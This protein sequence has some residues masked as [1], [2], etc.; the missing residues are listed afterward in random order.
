VLVKLESI[1]LV[2][3]SLLFCVSCPEPVAA[4]NT[5]AHGRSASPR[6]A[7]QNCLPSDL[8]TFFNFSN[9]TD[10]QQVTIT[11]HNIS[12]D[13]CVLQ[14]GEGA[15]FG[16]QGHG[17]WTEECRNCERD[18]TTKTV[19]SLEI[20]SGESGKMIIR[21]NTQA[22][23]P[24]TC[25]PVGNMNG[26]G[27]SIWATGL[28][29]D[30][31][32]VVYEDSYL[33]V[34]NNVEA[35]G[36]G[37][38][39]GA[40]SPRVNVTLSASDE[41]FYSN[42]SLALHVEIEDHDGTL[43]LNKDFCPLILMRMRG[44]GGVT[45]L[46]EAFGLC[47]VTPLVN[48]VGRRLSIDMQAQGWGALMDPSEHTVQAFAVLGSPHAA[49]VEMATSNIL[50]LKTLDP[51]SIPRPWGS[52]SQGVAMSL[53]FDKAAYAIGHDIP[54]RLE[55]PC[56]AG[57]NFELRN[58]AGQVITPIWGDSISICTGHGAYSLYP[59]GVV[60][61][62]AGF[63]LRGLGLLPSEPGK[64]SLVVTWAA[65]V[66]DPDHPLNTYYAAVGQPPFKPYAM[67]RSEPANFIVEAPPK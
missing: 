60:V 9:Q 40:S 52:Q 38:L 46:Q 53:S 21:W 58:S 59:K 47:R 8:D 39:T 37:T 31:C 2:L 48:E 55:L 66:A 3:A 7:V 49:D 23:A 33:R 62:V 44:T 67:V 4:Q 18:G 30:L 19:A 12:S 51:K 41:T 26:T 27:W 5:F 15:S 1:A 43:Q 65:Q 28:M 10:S 25:L 34:E 11:F 45:S 22:S 24:R 54:V 35:K 61:P 36:P 32:S 17:M 20:A 42:D 64:Y 50:S 29:R 6:P 57:F 16:G 14:S 13:I 56:F 63:T